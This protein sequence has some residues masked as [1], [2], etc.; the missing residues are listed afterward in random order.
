MTG[1]LAINGPGDARLTINKNG[2]NS[3]D[4][5]SQIDGVDMW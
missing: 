5:R 2:A 4:I 1:L 3:A